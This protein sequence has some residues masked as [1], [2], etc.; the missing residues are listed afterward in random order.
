MG[1]AHCPGPRPAMVT[2][3]AKT[4]H[5]EVRAALHRSGRQALAEAG[6]FAGFDLANCPRE[7]PHPNT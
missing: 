4:N 7:R 5:A 6:A 1:A 3:H 2:T